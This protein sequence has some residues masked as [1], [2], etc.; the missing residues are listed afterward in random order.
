MNTNKFLVSTSI[1]F[2]YDSN[3]SVLNDISFSLEKGDT[4][5]I[6]G[7]SGCGKS[8]LLRIISDILPNTKNNQMTGHVL[9]GGESPSN[10]LK[11]EKLAFM[12]QES[13]LLPNLTVKENV[14]LPL[15]IKGMEYRDKVDDLLKAV[16]LNDFAEYLPKK[17]SGGMKTRVALARSFVTDPELLLLDE[18]FSAL[19]IAW[20]SDL[21]IELEKLRER[22]NTTVI[23]VTHDVQEALL[24]S[25]HVIVMSRSGNL[26]STHIIKSSKSLIDRV[27]DIS[28]YL[29]DVYTD[30][31]L[32]IQQ[33]IMLDGKRENV[34]QFTVSKTLE[35]LKHIAGNEEEE[36][37]IS[38]KDTDLIRKWSKEKN[39]HEILVNTFNRAR[40]IE[41]RY[42]LVWDI[43]EYS[44]LSEQTLSVICKFYLENI[45]EC[46]DESQKWYKTNSSHV[47]FEI[48]KGRIEQC[49]S[50]SKKWIYLCDLYGAKDLP[51]VLSYLHS[52]SIGEIHSLNYPLAKEVA[53]EVA[54]RITQKN[55]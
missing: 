18:P 51:E 37:K 41:L 8:T 28:G 27:N 43:L 53:R 33:A 31:L 5:S 39:V 30:H 34:L 11:H 38:D 29:K 35:N 54:N 21:Y 6:V 52:V 55:R 17:L 42:R 50:Q 32:P 46:V 14:A 13:A 22:F 19:D 48:L 44:E 23:I 15:K 45:K 25:D 9:I 26:S 1:S 2:G 7:P 24:L 12:F 40:T 36:R 16:G 20:K 4:L 10:Y 47:L 49:P 3:K